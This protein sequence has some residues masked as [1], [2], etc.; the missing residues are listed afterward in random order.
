MSYVGAEKYKIE[1]I[2]SFTKIESIIAN[3]IKSICPEFNSSLDDLHQYISSKDVNALRLRVFK[4]LNQE[5]KIYDLLWDIAG[6]KISAILGPDV[7]A[8]SKI[9]FSVQMPGDET[10]TLGIH[11][12]CWSGDSPYQINLWLPFTNCFETN[13]MF[14][15]DFDK[16]ISTIKELYE[17]LKNSG[18]DISKNIQSGDFLTIERGNYLIFNPG[19]LHG[20]VKNLTNKTRASINIRYKSIFTPDAASAHAERSA[21]IYY[22]VFRQSAWTQLAIQLSN[23][24]ALNE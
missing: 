13:S 21:G 4:E 22:K 3:V 5:E 8:Q 24:N 17:N 18:F 9:N 10:S 19:L 7:L 16:T 2:D 6:S 11:S 14:L 15:F 20:N 1:K 23:I 12:D